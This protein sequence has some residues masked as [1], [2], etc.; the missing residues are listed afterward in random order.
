M[1]NER[2]SDAAFVAEVFIHGEGRITEICPARPI[3]RERAR[4]AHLRQLFAR[5]QSRLTRAR[6]AIETEGA[7]FVA[8]TV[9]AGEKDERVRQLATGFEVGEDAT[10]AAIDVLHHG[11]E[12]SHPTREV[13]AAI[14]GQAFPRRV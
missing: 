3:G 4:L 9:I 10:D 6:G 2:R 13:F 5:M 7:P 12:G 1:R 14:G 11:G 8:G